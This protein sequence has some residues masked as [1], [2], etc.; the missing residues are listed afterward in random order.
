MFVNKFMS[1]VLIIAQNYFTEIFSGSAFI[2]SQFIFPIFRY[3]LTYFETTV[4]SLVVETLL[5]P[6][7]A[8]KRSNSSHFRVY[9]Q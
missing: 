4:F 1:L 5:T 7:R 9:K 2:T 3:S 8:V 6:T